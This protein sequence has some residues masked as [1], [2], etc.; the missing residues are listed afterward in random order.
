LTVPRGSGPFA[1]AILITGSGPQDRDETLMGHRPFWVIAD[2]L[3]RRGIAV[4]RLDDRGVGKSTGN[5]ARATITD[6][7]GDVLAGVEFLKGRKQIDAKRIGV[8]GHSEGGI[9]GPL[10]ASMSSD[11]AFV[12]MLAG[13]GVPGDQVL[14]LQGEMV[15]KAAG[16]SDDAIAANRT[17]QKT[18]L[19]IMRAERGEK[20]E[21]VVTEKLRQAWAEVKPKGAGADVD[22]MMDAQIA[23]IVS[24]EIRS[25]LYHDPAPVLRSL[26]V[27]VLALNGSRDIQVPPSQNLPAIVAALTA[28]GNNDFM[29]AELP[30]LN[31]LFQKCTT[32]A[33][34][35]YS[36]LEETFSPTALE[37]MG[38]WVTRHSR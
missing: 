35:E 1:A 9:V 4:L 34:S 7:A 29:V 19:D 10:T 18:L 31:H 37:I 33:V 22:K 6:M 8:I 24:P 27:P 32:C 26:Q 16:A 5:S 13:T 20:D 21:K 3:T 28:G 15:A 17:I 30:G 23:G 38:D 14:A 11:I 36:Q 2:S 12:V 25:F